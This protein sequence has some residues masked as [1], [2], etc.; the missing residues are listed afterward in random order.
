MRNYK[1]LVIPDRKPRTT[2]NIEKKQE[3]YCVKSD[4]EFTPCHKCLFYIYNLDSFAEWYMA[5]N[6][7]K[8]EN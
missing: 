5:K 4:C 8:K 1:G 6:K 2:E 7:P 3:N